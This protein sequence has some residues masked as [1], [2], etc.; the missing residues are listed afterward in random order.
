MPKRPEPHYLSNSE[1]QTRF[2][3]FKEAVLESPPFIKTMLCIG[4]LGF[5]LFIAGIAILKIENISSSIRDSVLYIGTGSLMG[6]MIGI[7]FHGMYPDCRRKLRAQKK[8][9]PHTNP[10]PPQTVSV[11]SL[12]T[13]TYL[14]TANFT[15]LDA[16]QIQLL[17]TKPQP[18]IPDEKTPKNT[19]I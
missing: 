8:N 11:H 16:E 3:E 13:T 15:A 1:S 19:P 4:I 6:S 7:T 18:T 9:N 2:S 14:T 5:V 10:H 12:H 17:G